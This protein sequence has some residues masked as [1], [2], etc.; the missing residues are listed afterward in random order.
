MGDRSA[1]AVFYGLNVLLF[2]VTLVGYVPRA[3]RYRFDGEVPR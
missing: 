3:F 2:P 1:A